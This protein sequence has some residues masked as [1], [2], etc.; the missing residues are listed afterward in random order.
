MNHLS[1]VKKITIKN[2]FLF[3]IVFIALSV[4]FLLSL[5]PFSNQLFFYYDQARDAFSAYNIWHNFHLPILGPMTDIPGLFHGVFWYYFL[6]IPYFLGNGNPYFTGYFLLGLLFLSLPFCFYLSYK[7]FNNITVA[8]ITVI[9]YAFSPLFQISTRWI[10]NPT[11]SLLINPLLL[12]S[13]WSYINKQNKKYAILTGFSLGVIIHSNFA[14]IFFLALLPF[15]FLVFRIKPKIVDIFSFTAVLILTLSTF[16]LAEIK[17]HGRSLLALANYLNTPHSSQSLTQFPLEILNKFLELLTVSILPFST[18]FSFIFIALIFIVILIKLRNKPI[19]FEKKPIIFLLLWLT[20]IIFFKF[21]N[22][23]ISRSLFVFFPS[24]LPVVI[25]GSYLLYKVLNHSKIIFVVIFL[26]VYFQI[27]INFNWINKTINPLTVQEGMTYANELKI[28]DYTYTESKN[29]N[30]TINTIT[31]PLYINT[32]WAYVYQFY[33]QKKFGYLPFWDG[34]D[35][36]GL[37]GNLPLVKRTTTI[38][39]LIIEPTTGIPDFFV[40]EAINAENT[41]SKV[42]EEKRIGNFIVQKRKTLEIK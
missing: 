29:K 25:L 34:R 8:A 41:K 14:F 23:G 3:L 4:A 15:Y 2:K 20:N 10:S 13:L 11:L 9:L 39:Y 28:A 37:L 35:Q 27:S 30:F 6:A 26:I 7:L 1:L 17:F 21:F 31:S 32:T 12:I 40:K 38:R 36:Q 24:L 16:I 18:F 33:G 22:I 42:E 19:S 5:V